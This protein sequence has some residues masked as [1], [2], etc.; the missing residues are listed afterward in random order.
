MKGALR[1]SE[2]T[3][4]KGMS[5]R[6]LTRVETR[7]GFRFAPDHRLMLSVALP[8][9]EK[10]W[11]DWR[12]GDDED[13]RSRLDGPRDGIL[14]DVRENGFW[15]KE[16]QQRPISTEE[17][18]EVAREHLDQAPALVPLYGHRFL[19]TV[20]ALPGNPVLSVHQTDIIYYGNDLLD[21]LAYEFA[22]AGSPGP[23]ERRVPY[24]SELMDEANES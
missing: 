10:A 20:P 18:V 6:E 12:D 2:A 8:L 16:W 4:T 24:W 3:L 22:E 21:W 1:L 11:P 14:F 9:G 5:E 7:L 13:L 15:R 17:A 23:P 19:P